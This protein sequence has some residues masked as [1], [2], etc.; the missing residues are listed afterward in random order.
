MLQ[1]PVILTTSLNEIRSFRPCIEGWYNIL[2]ARNPQT[3]EDYDVQFPLV[4]CL[5]SNSVSDVC[6]LLGKRTK[7]ISIC[8]KFARM[9]ADSVA[10]MRTG[11]IA[12]ASA[13]AA[14]ADAASEAA[15]AIA[16][17]IAAAYAAQREKNKQFLRQCILEFIPAE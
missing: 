9:C 17:A 5:D 6:W 1:A 10:N 12:A 8:T 16:I 15:A 13:A 14:Y 3:P 4:D 11:K 7:E 2:K